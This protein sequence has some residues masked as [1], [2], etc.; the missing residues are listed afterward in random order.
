[1]IRSVVFLT[2]WLCVSTV[3][4][5]Y[6][7]GTGETP[8]SVICGF[9]AGFAM[10]ELIQAIRIH[11]GKYKSIQL[12][13]CSSTG[14]VVIGS[15]L[16]YYNYGKGEHLIM[17]CWLALVVVNVFLGYKQKQ[18]FKMSVKTD[19]RVAAHVAKYF[20]EDQGSGIKLERK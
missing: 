19:K 5:G 7:V 13:R 6:F 15:Y 1:M 8:Y 3:S 16:M 14:T 10:F 20:P 2:A 17:L 9:M 11:G 18:T 12:A 4:L